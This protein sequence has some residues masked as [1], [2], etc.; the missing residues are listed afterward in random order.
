MSKGYRVPS[1]NVSS[2]KMYFKEENQIAIL[3]YIKEQDIKVREHLYENKIKRP[4]EKLAENVFNTFKFQ[5]FEVGPLDAQRECITHLMENI[6]KFTEFKNDDEKYQFDEDLK[7][8]C[9]DPKTKQRTKNQAFSYFSVVAKHFYIGR[10][11]NNY[12]NN[13]RHVDFNDCPMN[14]KEFVVDSENSSKKTYLKEFI[15]LMINFWEKNINNLFSKE[16]DIIIA[17]SIIHLFRRTAHIEEF[18]KKAIYLY[19]REMTNCKTQH[20]TKVVNKMM[21]CQKNL[22][23]EFKNTGLVT[24]EMS[25]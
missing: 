23:R 25:N 4:F 14:Q 20:I 3:E 21:S 8:Y 5:Y 6:H 18:N 9:I 15:P 24:Q 7:L 1:E 22:S 12:K 11:N 13:Q 17:N 19:I 2:E 16:R 10:N